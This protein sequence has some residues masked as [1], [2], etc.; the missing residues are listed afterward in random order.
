MWLSALRPGVVNCAFTKWNPLSVSGGINSVD[1]DG[2]LQT[3]GRERPKIRKVKVGYS[4]SSEV[5]AQER[6]DDRIGRDWERA[7]V[8]RDS[9]GAI[10]INREDDIP[11]LTERRVVAEGAAP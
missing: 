2:V 3:I 10:S 1:A 8:C 6:K 9:T 7:A 5:G 4:V 11:N